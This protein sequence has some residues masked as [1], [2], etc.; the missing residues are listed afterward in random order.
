MSDV[1]YNQGF[2]FSLKSPCN[3]ASNKAESKDFTKT[4]QS[5]QHYPHANVHKS[6][7]KGVNFQNTYH[8]IGV[9]WEINLKSMIQ[10][11]LVNSENSLDQTFG[12]MSSSEDNYDQEIPHNSRRSNKCKIS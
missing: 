8:E 5:S 4:S 9:R 1:E 7:H 3:T 11:Q 12:K 10:Q 6:F 2:S